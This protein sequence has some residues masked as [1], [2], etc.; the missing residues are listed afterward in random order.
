MGQATA[1]AKYNG[2][3]NMRLCNM[4]LPH[5]SVC[6]SYRVS[7][8]GPGH[9]AIGGGNQEADPEGHHRR[10]LRAGPLRQRLQEQGRAG[11][12]HSDPTSNPNNHIPDL[13]L[14]PTHSPEPRA[15]Q[16]QPHE[17]SSYTKIFVIVT[18]KVLLCILMAHS[19]F[20]AAAGR[21]RR[22]PPVTARCARHEGAPHAGYLRRVVLS[23]EPVDRT[24]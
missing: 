11:R 4:N 14:D 7:S 19:P 9:R 2:A 12:Y 15:N 18:I 20:A 24:S 21:G 13:D 5:C 16:K 23:C 1:H 17:T 3:C 10:Q 6:G 22:V 8:P